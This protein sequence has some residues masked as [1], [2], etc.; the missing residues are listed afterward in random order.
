MEDLPV[1]R[2]PR[3]GELAPNKNVD[4]VHAKKS[5]GE[6]TCTYI[7]IW[8]LQLLDQI[9]PVGRFSENVKF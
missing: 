6:G 9:G 3:E 2:A 5:H 7:H 1:F 4:S 8:T